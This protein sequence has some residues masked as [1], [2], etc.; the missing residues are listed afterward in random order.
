MTR[1]QRRLF[2]V[3]AVGGVVALAAA[4][5]LNALS[6]AITYFFSPSELLALDAPPARAFRIGGLV[7]EGSVIQRTNDVEFAVTDTLEVVRVRYAGVLP[8]LFREGQGVIATGRLGPDGVV[9]ASQILAKHDEN[10]LPPE[11][12]EALK[13]TGRWRPETGEAPPG[14]GS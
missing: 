1:K 8:D 13:K 9:V 2:T 14:P 7:A 6:G 12:A 11:V 5:T 4:L 10:Y 3:G